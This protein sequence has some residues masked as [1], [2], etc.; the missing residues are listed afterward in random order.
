V[1]CPHVSLLKWQI[2]SA[3]SLILSLSLFTCAQSGTYEHLRLAKSLNMSKVI[4]AV[5]KMDCYSVHYSEARFNVRL[6]S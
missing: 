3:T 5:N 1:F 2:R 4:V 6:P